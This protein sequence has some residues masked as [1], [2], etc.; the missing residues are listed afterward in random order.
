MIVVREPDAG[1]GWRFATV[2][3]GNRA[4]ALLGGNWRQTFHF[5]TATEWIGC[6]ARLG[7]RVDVRGAGEGTP[8]RQC[9]LRGVERHEGRG[10][11]ELGVRRTWR[12]RLREA[13]DLHDLESRATISVELA[14]EPEGASDSL[15]TGGGP[16]RPGRGGARRAPWR[17]NRTGCRTRGPACHLHLGGAR[18]Q[19]P[20]RAREGS[21]ERSRAFWS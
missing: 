10:S 6:L 11:T 9:A 8:F 2:R 17:P 13:T 12:A 5:R 7:F 15:V 14:T 19:T 20:A 4:K 3:A 1:A 18:P 21:C 16:E